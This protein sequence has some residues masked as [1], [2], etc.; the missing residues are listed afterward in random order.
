MP[1]DRSEY[2][3]RV[4][5]DAALQRQ[6]AE[7]ELLSQRQ[8]TYGLAV[9]EAHPTWTLQQDEIVAAAK[10]RAL[11]LHERLGEA[12]DSLSAARS[13]RDG[14]ASW[15]VGGGMLS[16]VRFWRPS[17][18]HEAQRREKAQQDLDAADRQGRAAKSARV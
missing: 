16:H 2:Q 10:A 7:S 14:L 6:K 1:K 13:V 8:V 18:R 3:T 5:L 9:S 17:A 4:T 15:P 11:E 12:I